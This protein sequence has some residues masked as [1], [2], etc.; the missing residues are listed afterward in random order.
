[1]SLYEAGGGSIFPQPVPKHQH[2]ANFRA[3]SG[4]HVEID[5]CFRALEHPMLVPLRFS[6]P[7]Q[8]TGLPGRHTE[9]TIA[10]NISM[11]GFGAS[12]GTERRADMLNPQCVAS[13]HRSNSVSLLSKQ[14]RTAGLRRLRLSDCVG[15]DLGCVVDYQAPHAV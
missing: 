6:N 8:V 4:E 2:A 3:M 15:A 9:S 7:E 14:L 10:G 11:I 5:I 1:M 13:K 12:P